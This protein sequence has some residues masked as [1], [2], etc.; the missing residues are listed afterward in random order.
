MN[1]ISST[2]TPPRH[3]RLRH[4]LLAASAAVM[5]SAAGLSAA[6]VAPAV[7]AS[8]SPATV[9]KSSY[10]AFYVL[11]SNSNTWASVS[12]T[13][14][15]PTINCS[16]GA[17]RGQAFGVEADENGQIAAWAKADVECN[18][19]TPT[20]SLDVLANAVQFVKGGV[21]AGDVVVASAYQTSG[22]IQSTVHDLTSGV[23][24]IADGSPVQSVYA[25]AVYIGGTNTKYTWA[26]FT[27]TSFTKVQVNGDY[28]GYQSPT[29]FNYGFPG[30]LVARTSAIHGGDSFTL[31]H[32]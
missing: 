1:T 26:P 11:S 29:Q 9:Q 14:K 30:S 31:S 24:W 13:F 4:R 5:T 6:L 25:T 32:V 3:P 23:T 17:S 2:S 19:T 27:T 12:A 20:Y 21:S 28:L 8:A 16:S 7:A 15:V 10:G 18:G 22:V